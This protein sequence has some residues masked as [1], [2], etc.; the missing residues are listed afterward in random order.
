MGE[1]MRWVKQA[2]K[3]AGRAHIKHWVAAILHRSLRYSGVVIYDNPAATTA[4]IIGVS[5]LVANFVSGGVLVPA[6]LQ[7]MGFGAKGPI[8]RR[9]IGILR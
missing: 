6:A 1:A 4:F 5:I 3:D 7:A 9:S 8:K 2:L